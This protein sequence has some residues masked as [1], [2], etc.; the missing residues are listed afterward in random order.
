MNDKIVGSVIRV[1]YNTK[2]DFNICLVRID[3]TKTNTLDGDIV[4]SV[5]HPNIKNGFTGE[6]HGS[7]EVNAKYGKQ[8]KSK[9]VLEQ[10]PNTVNGFKNYLKSGLFKGIGETT[11]QKIVDFLGENPVQKLK[12][13]PDILLSV[14]KVKKNLLENIKDTWLGNSVKAEILILLQQNGVTGANIDRIY[15]KFKEKSIA[16]ISKNP[17][18]LIKEV[19]GIGFKIADKIAM[20]MG[21]PKDSPTRVTECIKHVLDSDTNYGSCYLIR[22]QIVDKVRELIGVF[23]PELFN[24]CLID[25]DIV[26]INLDGLDRYYSIGLYKAEQN[27]LH[28][29]NDMLSRQSKV[30]DTVYVNDL[31]LSKEQKEAVTGS[32]SNKLSI[33][34]GG[35]GCGKT[36]TTKTIVDNLIHMGKKVAICAPTG[37]AAAKSSSV[38]GQEALTI[39]RLLEFDF[40]H[41]YFTRNL[42]NPIDYD[43]L[44][45]EESSM[46]DI[47]L[48]ASLLVAISDKCQVLFVGDYAQ[49]PPIGAGSPFK[50]MIESDL[51]PTY[52]LNKIFRQGLNSDIIKSAHA[53]NNGE[54]VILRSPITEPEMWKGTTD[55]MFIDSDLNDGR[56]PNDYPVESTLRYNLDINKMI[57][58]LYTETIKKYRSIHEIQILIPKRVGVVGCDNINS[59]IQDIVNPES[60]NPSIIYKSKRF[61]LNDKVI[62]VKN[63]Y[64]LNVFNGEIG[65]IISVD[66]KN[67]TCVVLFENKTVVY[68]TY[69]LD[70]LELA[71]AITIHKSQ[72]SEFGCVIIPLIG[73]HAHM[74][75]R[76]L[77]YTGITRAKKLAIVIGKRQS[78]YQ[79]IAT[80]KNNKRQTSLR[81]LIIRDNQKILTFT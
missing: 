19:G 64:E 45:V 34:T 46:I 51:I 8:F 50:D 11:A 62:H 9:F 44:I 14:P 53:I 15:T 21:L 1:I 61:R 54:T 81:E 69:D 52:R 2:E 77:I 58:K 13:N 24:D 72:G 31:T 5:T 18:I 43:Y 67:R 48:M 3:K 63:N 78:F 41:G 30:F 32:L 10:L 71:F 26:K 70:D 39:H 22:T 16:V 40:I 47:K 74:S 33:L 57:I 38:I 65:K 79:G 59:I 37:K 42:Q 23:N 75:D 28:A 66:T 76:S 60:S 73:E 7:Y 6:F 12:D 56:R 49:L 29:I 4:V 68:K 17:Y 27:C 55:F 80:I 20:N 25:K 36:Y 35:P